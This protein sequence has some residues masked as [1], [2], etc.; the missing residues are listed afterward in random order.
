MAKN[1]C[2]HCGKKNAWYEHY[3]GKASVKMCRECA[4]EFIP[5]D[6]RWWEDD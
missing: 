1:Y 2:Y 3:T 5:H 6:E 4:E